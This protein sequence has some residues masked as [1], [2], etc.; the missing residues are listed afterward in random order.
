VNDSAPN[1][2][3][4]LAEPPRFFGSPGLW[5][6]ARVAGFVAIALW[7]AWWGHAI[8]GLYLVGDKYTQVRLPMFGADFWSQ[9]DYAARLFAKGI[10][11]YASRGHLFHYPPIVIRLFLWT[12]H[13]PVETALRIWVVFLILLIVLGTLAAVKARRRFAVGQLPASLAI[14]LVL[15]SSPVIFQLER[16][17]FDLITLAAIL[18]ALPLFRRE[19]AATDFLA[20]CVLA[21]GPWV[22]LYPGLMSLGLLA[23]RRWK[24]LAGFVV[25]GA[26][27]GL[28]TPRK[29]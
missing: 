28:L 8:Y 5:R 17:N 22:K 9:S 2:S 26:V 19:T 16:A 10:D 20:G 3:R 23:L 6:A 4:S 27:I 21:V 18:I 13:F 24:A 1:G 14:A 25:A 11:P 12:P 29:Q 15:F 7:V